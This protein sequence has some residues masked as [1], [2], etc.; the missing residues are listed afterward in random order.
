MTPDDIRT[1]IDYNY[2]ARNRMLASVA[3]L[4]AE[5]LTRPMGSSFASVLDTVT[6]IYMAEW[7]W[8]RRWKS[9]PPARPD[10][11][12]LSDVERIRAAWAPLEHDI[13]T[14]VDALGPEGLMRSLEYRS[15]AG[16]PATSLF[17]EMIVHVVNHGTYHRGQ[18][19][20]FL[21]QLGA[22]PAQSTDMIVFFRERA[23]ATR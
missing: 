17:W 16:Q 22:A 13:R 18:I 23:A 1:L 4:P 20:T 2:W 11:S 7:I 5:Q 9:E 19:A 14:F 6:H 8:Y 21:R 10:L 3:Q 15:L 12:G